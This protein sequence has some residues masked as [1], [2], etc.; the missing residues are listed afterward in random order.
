MNAAF[1]NATLKTLFAAGLFA[2]V[3]AMT[4]SA[5]AQIR[6]QLRL[7]PGPSVPETPRL[8]IH[9]HFHYGYGMIVDS[10]V[11]GTPASYAGLEPGDV[12]RAINGR[13]LQSEADYFRAL[14]YSTPYVDLLVQDVRTGALVSRTAV[15]GGSHYYSRPRV[16]L[17][18]LGR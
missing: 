2:V 13:T 16:G 11:L 18:I 17:T 12:I 6:P 8:G 9:G 5:Q 4:P 10:V 15:L 14:T 7:Y 3:M 1:K